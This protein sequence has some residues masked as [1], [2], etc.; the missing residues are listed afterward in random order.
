[1]PT[2]SPLTWIAEQNTKL[3]ADTHLLSYRAQ[4]AS[5]M[6]G[7]A[8]AVT[9]LTIPTAQ[10][11]PAQ[12]QFPGFPPTGEPQQGRRLVVTKLVVRDANG[13]VGGTAGGSV[14]IVNTTQSN[15]T[16]I[17]QPSQTSAGANPPYVIT[18]AAVGSNIV[19]PNDVLAVALTN[20][21]S[22]TA[23]ATAFTVDLFGYFQQGI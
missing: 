3:S 20:P 19:N 2:L 22:G 21:T 11:N 16:V 15:A 1:M 23:T 13:A 14:A 18:T 6:P 10:T 9:S 17:S 12:V 7:G 5:A 4:F 8:G